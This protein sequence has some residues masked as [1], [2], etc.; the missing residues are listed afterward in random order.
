MFSRMITTRLTPTLKSAERALQQRTMS[1]TFFPPSLFSF[2]ASGV[3]QFFDEMKNHSYGLHES[4]DAQIRAVNALENLKPQ[5]VSYVKIA[6]KMRKTK[7]GQR[8]SDTSVSWEEQDQHRSLTNVLLHPA[9]Y[10]AGKAYYEQIF[11]SISH[12]PHPVI[13]LEQRKQVY[14]I[15]GHCWQLLSCITC[16]PSANEQELTLSETMLRNESVS[17]YYGTMRQFLFH[18]NH[19][20]IESLMINYFRDPTELFN[21]LLKMSPHSFNTLSEFLEDFLRRPECLTYADHAIN[22]KYCPETIDM[23]RC[24]FSIL[25]QRNK[26]NKTVSL[27]Y[28]ELSSNTTNGMY[29]PQKTYGPV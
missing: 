7:D 6:E 12:L 22:N 17:N 11:S 4:L 26:D 15:T 19:R 3:K 5:L 29:A 1:M 21:R 20:L 9:A 8:C 14:E 10:S 18:P 24:I 25:N 2:H 27:I 23:M 28:Q 13:D 16:K